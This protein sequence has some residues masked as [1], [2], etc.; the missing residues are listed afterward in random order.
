MKP[1]VSGKQL[2]IKVIDLNKELNRK[3]IRAKKTKDRVIID[4][5]EYRVPE[6]NVDAKHS[7][8]KCLFCNTTFPGKGEKWYVKEAIKDWNER[9][10][11]YLNGEI[12]LEELQ[13]AK[14]RPALLV[15]FKG[16]GKDLRVMPNAYSVIRLSLVKVISGMLGKR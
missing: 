13:N 12:T 11:K 10:E 16:E 1:E 2:R 5:K 7:Y 9:Y 3:T 14:A 6:G 8:A 15:K 4:G